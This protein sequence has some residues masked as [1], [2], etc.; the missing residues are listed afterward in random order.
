M[1]TEAEDTPVEVPGKPPVELHIE[2][3]CT[4]AA[5]RGVDFQLGRSHCRTELVEACHTMAAAVG[6]DGA[7][8]AEA[9]AAVAVGQGIHSLNLEAVLGRYREQM[10]MKKWKSGSLWVTA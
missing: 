10:T 8:G 5:R 1:N 7:A 2:I 9:E 6:V 3:D 4:L